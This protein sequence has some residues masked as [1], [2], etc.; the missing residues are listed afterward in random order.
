MR[1]ESADPGG[2]IAA[3][4][5]PRRVVGSI[6]YLGTEIAE[7]GVIRHTE[8]NR[9]SLGEP[10][11]SRSDRCNTIAQA[12]IQAGLRAPATTRIPISSNSA[13]SWTVII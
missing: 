11:G 8:G 2:V 6:V 10:D 4:I 1:L 13:R 12:L 5:D 9:V 7:P 3:A